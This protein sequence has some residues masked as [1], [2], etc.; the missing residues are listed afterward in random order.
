MLDLRRWD[1][2]FVK[3]LARFSDKGLIPPLSEEQL[4]AIKIMEETCQ[5][6]GLVYDCEIGDIQFVSCCQILHSRT[7]FT[8][9]PPPKPQRYLLRTWIGTPEHEGG[10][11]LP[12]HDSCYPK[13]GGI[14][15]DNTPP[16]ADPLTTAGGTE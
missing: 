14:Q 15:V 1:P 11:C 7:G 13:R 9:P 5:R 4:E 6:N 2:Y 10:W 3:S 12:F 8:D 16:I